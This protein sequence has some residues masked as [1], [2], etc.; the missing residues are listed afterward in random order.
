MMIQYFATIRGIAGRSHE[1]WSKPEETIGDLL[2]D[3]CEKYGEHFRRWLFTGDTFSQ[4]CIVLVN[5]HDIRHLQGLN[6][7]LAVNDTVG[8][9]PPVAGGSC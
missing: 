6:T 9:F 7:P 2:R 1:E 8:I 3:L 4:M 5:G